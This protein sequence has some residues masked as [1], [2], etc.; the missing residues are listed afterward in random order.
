MMERAWPQSLHSAHRL[1]SPGSPA[2]APHSLAAQ[3]RQQDRAAKDLNSSF[4]L[5][6]LDSTPLPP[7]ASFVAPAPTLYVS[8]HHPSLPEPHLISV[9]LPRTTA[10]R[11]TFE[12]IRKLV[13]LHTKRTGELGKGVKLD[14]EAIRECVVEGMKVG[15]RSSP[16][17][18][19][20]IV[21]VDDGGDEVDVR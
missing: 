10:Y 20:W 2:R 9:S 15:W 4:L 13:C 16:E 7:M 5:Y 1:V 6:S 14:E 11:T 12:T 21:V 19:S 8:L 3:L 18:V 17:Q